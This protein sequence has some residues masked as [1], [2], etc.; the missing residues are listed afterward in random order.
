MTRYAEGTAVTP[1]RSREEIERT[2]TRFGAAQFAYAW[3]QG[4]AA[5]AFEVKGRQIRFVL[6]M[7]DRQDRQFTHTPAR[8]HRRSTDAASEAFE[9]AVRERWRSLALVIKAKLAAVEAGV[10]SFEDEF[11]AH[12]VLPGGATVADHVQPKVREAYATGE[13]PA[14]LPL[15]L[16]EE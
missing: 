8:G 5:I 16:T 10:V 11:L 4:R 14:L 13:L 9:Q 3:D 7:P 12:T 1:T 15:Q 2:L 6:P